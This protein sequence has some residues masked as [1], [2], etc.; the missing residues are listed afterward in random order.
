MSYHLFSTLLT[1]CQLAELFSSLLN[2]AAFFSPRLEIISTAN[3]RN[4]L[5]MSSILVTC[6]P[7]LC[8]GFLFLV[9]Y[10][11]RRLLRLLTQL[12]HTQLC[13]THTQSFTHNLFHTQLCHSHS[14]SHSHSHTHTHTHAIFHTQPPGH[15]HTHNFVTHT[16]FHTHTVFFTQ[17]CHTHTHNLP[18]THTHTMTTLS[19]ATLSHRIFHTQLCRKTLSHNF[20]THTHNLCHTRNFVT[21]NLSHT[22]LSHNTT[23]SHTHT[24][25]FTHNFVTHTQLRHFAW[26]AWRLATSTFLLRN[27]RGP[28]RHPSSFCVA[29]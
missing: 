4:S 1:S 9:L 16:I 17:L 19:H 3:C 24:Q 2:A 25:S 10:P 13:H 28:W 22:T 8:V 11:V 23:L 6:S 7:H 29:D 12:C 18:H 26:E 14:H 20:V 5:S 15:T 27:R 21:Q